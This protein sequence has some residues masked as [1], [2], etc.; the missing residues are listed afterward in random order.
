MTNN[1]DRHK[2]NTKTLQGMY[3]PEPGSEAGKRL[4]K[5]SRT[6]DARPHH[7]AKIKEMHARSLATFRAQLESGLVTL[8]MKNLDF[9]WVN[10]TADLCSLVAPIF[11]RVFR[12]L[13]H[14]RFSKGLCRA[15]AAI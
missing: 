15:V 13:K 9:F 1:N 3:L 14:F 12:L 4:E 2:K 10:I 5:I 6:L 8:P 11:L 7:K